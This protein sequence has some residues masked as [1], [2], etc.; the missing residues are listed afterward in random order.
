LGTAIT[1][2]AGDS[3]GETI[4]LTLDFDGAVSGL[5]SG[6]NS[7]IFTVGGSGVSA[8]WSGTGST[9]TLTYT[10]A[11]GQS[12]Q[13]AI[14][15]AALKTALIAGITD[16]AGNAFAYSGSIPTIDVSPLPVV[17]TTGPTLTNPVLARYIRIYHNASAAR[18]D[19]LSLTGLRAMVGEVDV[20]ANL[21]ATASTNITAGTDSGTLNTVAFAPAA[22]VDSTVG[23]AFTG[24]SGTASGLAYVTTTQSATAV[25][26]NKVFID[27]DLGAVYKIDN[28]LLWGRNN[29]DTA[30]QSDN[31]RVFMGTT[32]PGSQTYTQL[33]ASTAFVDV[34]TVAAT[35][36]GAG[37]T[38][39]TS[40][41]AGSVTTSTLAGSAGNSAGE[42]IAL[43]LTFDGTVN[44]LS[45]GTNSTIFTVG[46]SGV[47]AT[48][49]GTGNTRTLTYTIAAG[50]NGQA[51]IDEAALKTALIAGISDA[52]GNAFAYSGNIPNIDAS[53]LPV[54]DTRFDAAKDF[55]AG[56][57]AQSTNNIWQYFSANYSGSNI[58]DLQLL[59]DWDLN[60]NGLIALNQWDGNWTDANYPFV[61]KQTNGTLIIHPDRADAGGSGRAVVVAWKNTTASNVTVDLTGSLSLVGDTLMSFGASSQTASDDGITYL[62]TTS[63]SV[64]STPSVLLQGSLDENTGTATPSSTALALG[65]QILAPGAMISVA[66]HRGNTYFWDHTQLDLQITPRPATIDLGS[67][68]QLIAPVQV[69]GKWY[70]Y[71]DRSGDGTASGTD[72]TSH[73]VLDGLFNQDIAGVTNTT[74]AN[75]D[76]QYGTTD[77]YRYG[78]LNGVRVA[79]PTLNGEGGV[80]AEIAAGQGYRAD[81]W[82]GTAYTDAGA[83]SNGTTGPYGDFIAIWDAYNGTGTESG[84]RGL[85]PQWQGD[86]PWTATPGG[87][88]HLVGA[89]HSGGVWG[90]SVDSEPIFYVALQVL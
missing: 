17:D 32:A 10:I 60:G 58:S 90:G 67:H 66:V 26:S 3:T 6:T 85:P 82:S 68:G 40:T 14:D 52:A 24:Q 80:S 56:P 70:Y 12:G 87:R 86:G 89:L 35:P 41:L 61:Q 33:S 27:V 4:T 51:A 79:L 88:G 16:A 69:E 29:P 38:V 55:I 7:A 74:V 8:T 63:A 30:G 5:S 23:N 77:T 47:S 64:S 46:G 73:D 21:L 76:G 19:I 83:T 48:W 53:A 84:S 75:A 42:T 49:S 18:E 81:V 13:A 44:G 37:T 54:V 43:T 2:A 65:G 25:T 34:G 71:W 62:V 15:E 57:T 28:L 72:Y 59:S 20:A 36:A 78:T 45:S 31:L 1:G 11:A 22:L 9:R 39:A 50:Q